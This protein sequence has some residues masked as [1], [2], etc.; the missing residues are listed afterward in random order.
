MHNPLSQSFTPW[1]LIKFTM[2][3]IV[4]MIFLSLYTM[5]D[6]ALVSR[7]IGENA[8]AAVNMVYPILSVVVAI[9]I[10]LGTGGS[11]VIARRMGQGQSTEAKSAFSLLVAVGA[12]IGV[13]ILVLGTVFLQPLIHLVGSTPALDAFSSSYLGTLLLFTPQSI[14]QMLFQ[15]LFVTAGRPHIGLW[16]TVA[17]GISNLVL[18]YVFIEHY[19]FG[20][21]G[22]AL[23]TGIGYSIPAGVGLVYFFFNKKGSLHF[24]KPKWEG[25]ML[26]QSCGNG[27]SEMV[28]NLA[29]AVTTYL[30]N[31]AMLHY[32]G[33]NGVAAITIVLYSQFLLTAVYLGFSSGVAPVI[34]YHYGYQNNQELH[35]L[36][37]ISLW[38]ITISSVVM[39]VV[40]VGLASSVT[41]IFVS[42][43]SPVFDLA[44]KGFLLFSPT[45]L[46]TGI[47]IFASS[48]FTA[49]SNGKVSALISFLRTFIILVGAVLVLPLF[50]GLTGIWLAVPVAELATMGVSVVCLKHYR[51]EYYY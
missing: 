33:E 15:F 24:I 28:T 32:V 3:T 2:P 12:A 5:V 16:A 22:A 6:G 21:A 31:I 8:L 36:Y 26:L 29:T 34:S 23:A 40:S 51:K 20:I 35:K 13:I 50:L 48:L 17:G 4:N 27:S 25:K 45:Y 44:V 1:G 39:L 42:R 49:F 18:D 46:F 7:L 10:M 30:F 43:Q 19:G 14:L 9:G 47:N 11:A 37:R 38:T 41:T